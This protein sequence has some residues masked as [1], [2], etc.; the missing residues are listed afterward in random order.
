[1]ATADAGEDDGF[2]FLFGAVRRF[3]DSDLCGVAMGGNLER[4]GEL[5]TSKESFARKHGTA[6]VAHCEHAALAATGST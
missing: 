2:E 3:S 5:L 6:P 4:M 1:M